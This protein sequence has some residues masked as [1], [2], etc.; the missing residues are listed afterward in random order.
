MV[1][2]YRNTNSIH[3]TIVHTYSYEISIV[4]YI[5]VRESYPLGITCS[6]RSVLDIDR[7]VELNL[8][9]TLAQGLIG[10]AFPFLEKMIRLLELKD[11]LLEGCTRISADC[12]YY[13]AER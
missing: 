5:M 2:G 7:I 10:D 6:T 4:Q 8:F 3:M 12:G 13:A 1:K 11:R 9:L